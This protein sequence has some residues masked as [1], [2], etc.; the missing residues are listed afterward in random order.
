MQSQQFSAP[1]AHFPFHLSLLGD[2]ERDPRYTGW[3]PARAGRQRR[4]MKFPRM[5]ANLG[6]PVTVR[7]SAQNLFQPDDQTRFLGKHLRVKS[8]QRGGEAHL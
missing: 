1:P 3:L 6:G 2:I 4:T 7:P 5:T 8:S